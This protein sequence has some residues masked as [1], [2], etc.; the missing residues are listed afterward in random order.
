MTADPAFA[1]LRA[2]NP[3]PPATAVDAAALFEHIT[4]AAPD[5]RLAEPARRV[6]RRVL[7]FAVALAVVAVLASTAFALSSWIGS[8]IGPSE[9]KSEFTRAETTLSLPPG[10]AWPKLD[11]PSDSVTSRGA[12]GSFAVGIAQSAWECYWARSIRDR[13]VAGER[14]A[15]AALRDLMANHVV[16]APAGASENWSPPP[17][18]TPVAVFADD[19][20]YQF[21]QRM[22]E[23]AAAGRPQLLQQSCRA[24]APPGWKR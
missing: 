21:K 22:Y 3:C 4:S 19:G 8:I 7:V 9:V 15:R 16:V 18:A 1:R 17:A 23:E 12:G 14:T 2:A 11:F 10:Y 20:G 24:N 5:R 6:S 13:D